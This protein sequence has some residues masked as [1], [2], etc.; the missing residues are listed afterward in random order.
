MRILGSLTASA[1]WVSIFSLAFQAPVLLSG[2]RPT[3]RRLRLAAL[4]VWTG[5]LLYAQSSCSRFPGH[6]ILTGGPPILVLA[7]APLLTPGISLSARITIEGAVALCL[8][9]TISAA[10]AS[11]R[12]HRRLSQTAEELIAQREAAEN[13][14]QAKSDFLAMMSHELRTPLNGV[15]GLAHAL[16]AT[17]LTPKQQSLLEGITRSATP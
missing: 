13:A 9:H 1:G 5:M 6:F 14:S 7:L 8:V 2:S 11:Y 3:I 15:L 4:A 10:L 16:A 17:G 12:Q